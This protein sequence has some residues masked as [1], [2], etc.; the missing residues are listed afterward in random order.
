MQGFAPDRNVLFW[1]TTRRSNKH[2][3]Q[4]YVKEG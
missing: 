1:V 3:E 4:S 2:L